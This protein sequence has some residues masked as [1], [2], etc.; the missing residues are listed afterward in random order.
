[1]EEDTYKEQRLRALTSVVAYIM[2]GLV[3]I[4]AFAFFKFIGTKLHYNLNFYVLVTCSITFALFLERLTV[5]LLMHVLRN[6]LKKLG[7]ESRPT[8]SPTAIPA[9]AQHKSGVWTVSILLLSVTLILYS[10]LSLLTGNSPSAAVLAVLGLG[11]VM[12]LVAESAFKHRIRCGLFGTTEYEARQ[13][14]QF[15]LDN[16]DQVDF[17]DGLGVSDWNEEHAS[18]ELRHLVAGWA[19]S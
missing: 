14:L 9:L 17:S 10:A 11:E 19:S 16:S 2:I 7:A 4:P 1:M 5:L 18:E 8:L 12:I 15:V 3:S 13:I 6:S